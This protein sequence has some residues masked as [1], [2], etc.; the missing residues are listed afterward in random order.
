MSSVW[1][2]YVIETEGGR[3]YTGVTTDLN[4]R[5]RQHAAQIKGGAKF[6]RSDPPS[7]VLFVHDCQSRSHALRLEAR[8]KSFSRPEK[9]ALVFRRPA[10]FLREF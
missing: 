1:S 3:F 10:A 5:F 9:E 4:Q 2:V 7:L 6:F 8:I